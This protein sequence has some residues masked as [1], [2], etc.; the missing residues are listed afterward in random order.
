MGKLVYQSVG[1]PGRNVTRAF[2]HLLLIKSVVTV[3]KWWLDAESLTLED[4]TNHAVIMIILGEH[5]AGWMVL[6]RQPDRNAST[7]NNGVRSRWLMMGEWSEIVA[8]AV[9]LPVPE[10]RGLRKVCVAPHF[11]GQGRTKW[12]GIRRLEFKKKTHKPF[13]GESCIINSISKIIYQW[14]KLEISR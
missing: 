11:P 10:A 13:C 9:F 4:K 7:E 14:N 5:R 2:G 3:R 1:T 6:D 12:T 8:D